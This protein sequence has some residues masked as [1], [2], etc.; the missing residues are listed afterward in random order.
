M[1]NIPKLP[2]ITVYP[3]TEIPVVCPC[4]GVKGKLKKEYPPEKD[5]IITC[6]KCKQQV[7]V[8]INAREFY[9]KDVTIEAYYQLKDSNRPA[10]KGNILN[11]SRG[12]LRLKCLKVAP[13]CDRTGNVR[14][15]IGSVMSLR[16]VLPP[17]EEPVR[18]FGEIVSVVEETEKTVTFGVRFK[19]PGE[20]EEMQIGFFL[21]S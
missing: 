1:A 2:V 14:S 3:S 19:N 16:F 13:V 20:Y 18:V 4:C 17:K 10:I 7:F 15:R 5:F 8:R 12:G 9:R 11:I 21:Q 6:P